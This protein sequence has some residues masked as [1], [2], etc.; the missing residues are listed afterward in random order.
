MSAAAPTL[1]TDTYVTE[2]AELIKQHKALWK[3]IKRNTHSN[4]TMQEKRQAWRQRYEADLKALDAKYDA[5]G[6]DVVQRHLAQ[7]KV[8]LTRRLSPSNKR[9]FEETLQFVRHGGMPNQDER[10]AEAK[11]DSSETRIKRR[12]LPDTYDAYVR[13]RAGLAEWYLQAKEDARTRNE[14]KLES[15][16]GRIGKES[17]LFLMQKIE[18]RKACKR[19]YQ[20]E[21]KQQKVQLKRD[22]EAE[23]NTIYA[24]YPEHALIDNYHAQIKAPVCPVHDSY[25]CVKTFQGQGK[26]WN[27]CKFGKWSHTWDIYCDEERTCDMAK[28]D[29]RITEGNAHLHRQAPPPRY[30]KHFNYPYWKRLFEEELQRSDGKAPLSGLQRLDGIFMGKLKLVD[31]AHPLVLE[32]A[33]YDMQRVLFQRAVHKPNRKNLDYDQRIEEYK[34][35]IKQADG[36]I[37]ACV[38]HTCEQ[39]GIFGWNQQGDASLM[40]KGGKPPMWG[41]LRV[42]KVYVDGEYKPVSTNVKDV[43]NALLMPHLNAISMDWNRV[44]MWHVTTQLSNQLRERAPE[45]RLKTLYSAYVGSGSLPIRDIIAELDMSWDDFVALPKHSNMNINDVANA[46]NRTRDMRDAMYADKH[47]REFR[48][49]TGRE[50][51]EQHEILVYQNQ[52]HQTQSRMTRLAYRAICDRFVEPATPFMHNYATTSNPGEKEKI[53]SLMTNFTFEADEELQLG[54]YWGSEYKTVEERMREEEN[55]KE[56]TKLRNVAS[57]WVMSQLSQEVEL[58]ELKYASEHNRE[59]SRLTFMLEAWLRDENMVN[60]WLQENSALEVDYD[61]LKTKKYELVW[62]IQEAIETEVLNRRRRRHQPTF[63][64]SV[65]GSRKRDDEEYGLDQGKRQRLEEQARRREQQRREQEA[66]RREQVERTMEALCQN[67]D[68]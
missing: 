36:I 45:V 37:R 64:E 51:M 21:L 65:L 26:H 60:A 28:R 31:N 4:G 54:E 10:R 59:T 35:I 63:V 29:G 12:D 2:R 15:A 3:T 68:Y 58:R 66:R 1:T 30:E 13:A 44:Q 5:A 38:Y 6:I 25:H 61:F 53:Q 27:Q 17:G 33:K 20:E 46:F 50:H 47:W 18:K 11:R 8:R 9:V 24:N 40:V 19:K 23:R 39:L 49:F 43:L 56:D 67:D 42:K 22:Y 14:T 57:A 7:L 32:Y 52:A 34:K 62:F 41:L 55:K 16:L 48:E